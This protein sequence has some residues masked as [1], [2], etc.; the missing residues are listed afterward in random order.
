MAVNVLINTK[1]NKQL[2]RT[3]SAKYRT[4]LINNSVAALSKG[5]VCGRSLAGVVGS[6]CECCVLSGRH[7]C[8]GLITRPE[9]SYQVW[10]A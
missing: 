4:K 10:C 9:K 2:L 8:V 6:N 1:S 7:L 3:H 5:W